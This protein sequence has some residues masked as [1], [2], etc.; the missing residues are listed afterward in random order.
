MVNVQK[1]AEGKYLKPEHVEKS[2]NKIAVIIGSSEK[3]GTYGMQLELELQFNKMPKTWSP[4]SLSVQN[5]VS[6]YGAESEDWIGRKIELGL[7][8]YNGKS[9]IIANG[10]TELVSADEVK[11]E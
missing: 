1:Y 11:G 8:E 10:L 2:K 5:I 9:I 3:K 4:N 7:E 6:M